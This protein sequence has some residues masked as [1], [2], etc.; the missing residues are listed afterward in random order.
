MKPQKITTKNGV[1]KWRA[2]WTVNGHEH[3]RTF[4]TYTDAKDHLDAV[5]TDRVTGHSVDPRDGKETVRSYGTRWLASQAWEASTIERVRGTLHK[6]IFP[7]FGD[8]KIGSLRHSELQGFAAR[9]GRDPMASTTARNIWAVLSTMLDSA[10]K[11]RVIPF[12]PSADVRA[13]EKT[14][15]EITIPT[16]AEVAAL[17]DATPDRYR[18]ATVLAASQGLRQGEAHGLAVDKLTLDDGMPRPARR[19]AVVGAPVG[20]V[21]RVARQLAYVSGTGGVFLKEPKSAAGIRDL[22][23]TDRAHADLIA[24]IAAYPPA[25][26][27]LP[28]LQPTGRPITVDLLIS[29]ESGQ[30]VDRFTWARIWRDTAKRAG[31]PEVRYHDLRH[32][33]VS[34]MIHFGAS[35]EDVRIF[36]GH[37]DARTTLAIYVHQ[38]ENGEDRTLAA[39]NAAM[40]SLTP[41]RNMVQHHIESA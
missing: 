5:T 40:N 4:P 37:S 35:I 41:Q 28:W 13:P 29:D 12:D 32:F 17:I 18:I 1:V 14:A 24:H 26:V 25:R 11:D 15:S 38:F 9:L 7:A 22:R 36:C 10:V 8:R 30:P 3:C 16:S 31:C 6:W 20:P 33:A 27:V 23:L 19:L 2:R 21:L 39:L 34:A